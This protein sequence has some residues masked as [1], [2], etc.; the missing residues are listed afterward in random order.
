MTRVGVRSEA[1]RSVAGR[2]AEAA[3]EVRAEASAVA[4][5]VARCRSP[6]LLRAGVLAAW[7]D[8]EVR[9]LHVA[10]PAGLW[11]AAL[12]LDALGV[13]LAAA[14]RA[15]EEVERGVAGLLDAVRAGA[16]LAA[17][18]GWLSDSGHVPVLRPVQA[19]WPGSVLRGPAD[20]VALGH[21]LGGARV[22]VVEVDAGAGRSAWVV[23]VP[24]TQAWGPRAG[25]NPFDLTSDVR[26][27]T[28]AATL[29]AAGVAAALD[30]A[31]AAS[32]RAGS[33]DAV[34]LV[35]HSQ[36][37]IHA[38]ALAADPGFATRHR[39]TH[40]VTSGAPV[41]IF[42]IPERVRVL[43]VEHA[44]DPVPAL[45]LTPNPAHAGWLTLRVGHGPPGDLRRHR[46]DA[47]VATVRAAEQAPRGTVPGLD[48][49]EASAGA[50]LH[51]PVRGVTEVALERDAH[52]RRVGEPMPP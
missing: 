39:V 37:G 52:R 32:G 10:G 7:L 13:R 9:V 42:P 5:A 15:Y 24:G 26:A 33:D 43:S 51:R 2:L 49:W 18:G 29:A 17:R 22:R 6:A 28:G 45:D 19:R 14:A 47:Y 48:G 34:I 21:G 50:V 23:V 41:G 44:E 36:G 8:I 3:D 12:G 25:A 35:G 16:D 40:V 38:A 27:V 11:G 4:D 20:L 30:R 46:L 1:L 31:M